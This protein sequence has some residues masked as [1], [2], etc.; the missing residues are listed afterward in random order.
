VDCRVAIVAGGLSTR[1]G[2]PK[3]TAELAG[4]RLIDYPLAAAQTAGL[5]AVVV[6]KPQSDLPSLG[7]PLLL[8]PAEPQ[9]PLCGV[10]AALR[11]S[12]RPVLAVAC[13]MPFLAPDLLAWLASQPEPLV[14]AETDRGLQPLLA[15]Y[16]PVLTDGLEEGL[17]REAPMQEVVASLAPRAVGERVLRRF[18][19]PQ[20]LCFNVNSPSDLARAE[21][22]LAAARP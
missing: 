12:G 4:R 7:V 2:R 6:A 22:M 17:R 14:V 8:E 13:D 9:H 19:D 10:V 3:A 15:R 1:L 11:E 5:E 20:Q 18:G 16:D 21:R